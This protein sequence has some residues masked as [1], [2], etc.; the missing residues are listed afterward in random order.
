MDSKQMSHVF[1]TDVIMI[2]IFFSAGQILSKVCPVIKYAILSNVTNEGS[3][4]VHE[5]IIHHVKPYQLYILYI[6][7]P[8]VFGD[9]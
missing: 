3:L 6:K 5:T 4:R 7:S 2:T 9:F 8:K 1:R